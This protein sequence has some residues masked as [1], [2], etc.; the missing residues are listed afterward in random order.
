MPPTVAIIARKYTLCIFGKCMMAAIR[1]CPVGKF[2]VWKESHR[3][4]NEGVQ[5]PRRSYVYSTGREGVSHNRTSVKPSPSLEPIIAHVYSDRLSSPLIC[6]RPRLHPTSISA[7]WGGLALPVVW[8]MPKPASR[9]FTWATE[10]VHHGI[11]C[12][13]LD[14]YGKWPGVFGT[15]NT[16]SIM[17]GCV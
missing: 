15:V 14:R 11:G 2:F 10:A 5:A 12:Q 4:S 16:G 13:H 9:L 17:L 1:L 3:N 7:R 6:R 8:W